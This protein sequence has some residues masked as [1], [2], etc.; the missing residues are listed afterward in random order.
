MNPFRGFRERFRLPVRDRDDARRAVDEELAAHLEMAIREKMERGLSPEDARAEALAE[1][2]DLEETRRYCARLTERRE[3]DVE[4]SMRFDRV[5]TDFQYALRTLRKAP[6]FTF[7][8]VAT[9]GLGIAANTVVFSLLNPYFV[10]ELPFGEPE[11]LVQVHQID[12]VSGWTQGRHSQAQFQ[13][14]K[15]RSQALDDAGIYQYG[16]ANVTG[17]EGPERTMRAWMSGNMWGVLRVRAAL[18]R[19]FR[20]DEAGPG[21][22]DVAVLDHGFWQRRYAGDPE[23]LGRTIQLDGVAHTVVGVMPPDFLFPFPEVKVWTPIRRSAVEEDRDRAGYIMVARLRD[24]WTPSRAREELRGI[25]QDLAA[26][27]PESDAD[28]TGV[29]I[30]PMREA[31]NFMWDVLR[32]AFLVTGV[33]MIFVLLIACVNVAGL[34]LGRIT[35]RSREVAVRSALGAG[36]RQIVGQFLIEALVLAVGG[37]VL[38]VGISWFVVEGMSSVMPE[39]LYRVGGFDLDGSVLLFSAALTLLTPLLFAL[40]PALTASRTDL[41]SALRRGGRGGTGP[42]ALLGRRALV[43][44]QVALGIVLISGAGLMVRSF[45]EVQSL[46]LGYDAPRILTVEASLPARSY[47][48]P[49]QVRAFFRRAVDEAEALPGVDRAATVYPLPMNHETMVTRVAPAG[50]AI[51]GDEWPGATWFRVSE[52]YF[53]TMGIGVVAGRTFG[54]GD[55]EEGGGAVVVNRTL[56]EREWSGRSPVGQTVLYGEPDDPVRATVV[57]V[58]QDVRHGDLTG[59]PQPQIYLPDARSDSRRR[60]VVARTE[61]PPASLVASAREMVRRLDPSLPV[62]IRPLSDVVRESTLQWAGPSGVL[63]AF[64]LVALLLASLGLYGVISYWVTRRRREMGVRI[65]LGARAR[66]VRATVLKE[67]L[68]LTAIGILIGVTGA[69][70]TGKVMTSVLYGV[71]P[72]DLPTLAISVGVFLAVAA[73]ASFIPALRASRVDPVTALRSE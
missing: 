38:G 50:S 11:R 72:F 18:G 39:G 3:R 37:G 22:E 48:E 63:A 71:S 19:T 69:L 53:R 55:G 10:R 9:L 5:W 30:L 12:A 73:A 40:A 24:G 54:P 13:D 47:S 2:G 62:A 57:G 16:F 42:R 20:P 45:L 70:A 41:T 21:G 64:G 8:V 32:I 33:A 14:W 6:A 4:T 43:V 7:I 25:Q 52:G 28:V 60:F 23:I 61:G 1:F 65:A 34:T 26:R 66:E 29:N 46:E 31:L 49:D 68:R 56:A 15:A 36:R 67:G 58:V 59:G 27:Y 17:P 51:P 35:A 44:A